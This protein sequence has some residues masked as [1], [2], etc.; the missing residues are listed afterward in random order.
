MEEMNKNRLKIQDNPITKTNEL[1]NLPTKDLFDFISQEHSSNFDLSV[2]SLLPDAQ[3]EDYEEEQFAN[4]MKKRKK[5]GD[6]NFS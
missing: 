6:Y 5:A 3:G 2:F 4:R 1:D